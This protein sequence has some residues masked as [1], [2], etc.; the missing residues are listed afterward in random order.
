MSQAQPKLCHN[1]SIVHSQ[2]P[3]CRNQQS[4]CSSTMPCQTD[5]HEHSTNPAQSPTYPSYYC[6]NTMPS[7]CFSVVC[8]KLRPVH[9]ERL[10]KLPHDNYP[11]LQQ[12]SELPERQHRAAPAAPAALWAQ[13]G[14]CASSSQAP[15]G[16]QAGSLHCYKGRPNGPQTCSTYNSHSRHA[17]HQA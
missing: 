9:S 5:I 8:N 3:C 17:K 6:T 1:S 2:A 13:V 11:R 10:A 4:L 7:S 16:L 14:N 15:I 12:L